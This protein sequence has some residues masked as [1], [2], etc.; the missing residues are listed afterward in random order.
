MIDIH[1]HL[2]VG[3]DDGPRSKAEMIALVKQAKS[4]GITGSLSHRITCIHVT[5]M[6][7]HR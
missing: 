7:F 5:P 4:E 6:F 1:N 3:I 2:L